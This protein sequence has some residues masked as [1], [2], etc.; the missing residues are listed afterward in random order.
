MVAHL[1]PLLKHGLILAPGGPI[2]RWEQA[3]RFG[4]P[5]L[6][7]RS[8][9]ENYQTTRSHLDSGTRLSNGEVGSG[10]RTGR[11]APK[12]PPCHVPAR[13]PYRHSSKTSQKNRS[14][15]K[16][17]CADLERMVPMSAAVRPRASA[18]D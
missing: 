12:Q 9:I 8:F 1:T 5:I 15:W 10:K 11:V 16:Q 13:P 7:S 14:L 17:V 4:D 18:A 6:D 2:W 3:L